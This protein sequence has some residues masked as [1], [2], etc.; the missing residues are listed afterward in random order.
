MN[1]FEQLKEICRV[2]CH[3]RNACRHGFEALMKTENIVQIMQVWKENWDDV[4]RS[5]YADI[6]VKQLSVVGQPMIEE[7]RN[8]GVY[9]NENRDEG[10]VIISN[11]DK[12]VNVSGTAK[13][14]IFTSAEVSATDNAQ[15]YCRAPGSKITLRGHAYC[16]CESRDTIVS[17]H[18]FAHAD[19]DMQCHTYNAA[20]VVMANGTLF[21]HGHRRIA[22]YGGTKVYS[23]VTKGIELGGQSRLYPLSGSQFD[24]A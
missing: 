3:E 11:P 16:H 17:V 10:Y 2:A 23:D 7:F 21:D 12:L 5:R 20:E 19:G 1:N 22:A 4:Y 14:Y 9:V 24:K 13:A 18:N 15:V 8:G 6:M